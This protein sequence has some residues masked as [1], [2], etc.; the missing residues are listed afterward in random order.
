MKITIYGTGCPKCKHLHE[1][2]AA[3]VKE[4]NLDCEIEKIDDIHEI[5]KL[6]VMSMPVLMVD[7]KIV[8]SGKTPSAQELKEFLDDRTALTGSIIAAQEP[9]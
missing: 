8:A 2:T 6:N 9:R 1:R 3:V 5:L 7:G 4:M